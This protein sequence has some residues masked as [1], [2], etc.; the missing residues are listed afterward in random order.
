M[1]LAW[2]GTFKGGLKGHEAPS[3][4]PAEASGSSGP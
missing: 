3:Q 1:G 4:E 2:T